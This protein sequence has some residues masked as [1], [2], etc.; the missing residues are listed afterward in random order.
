MPYFG[1][2]SRIAPLVWERF[3]RVDNLVDPFFGSGAILLAAPWPD[4]RIETVNDRDGLLTNFWRALRAFPDEVAAL[5]DYPVSELDL[6]ARHR[7]LV[8]RRAYVEHMQA[9]PEWCDVK[10][11]AW[12]V[13]GISQWIGSGWCPV[14]PAGVANVGQLSRQMPHVGDAGRGVHRAA[15]AHAGLSQQV[16][17]LSARG[18]GVAAPRLARQLPNVGSTG[19]GGPCRGSGVHRVSLANDNLSAYFQALAD[20]LRRVRIV[21]GDWTRVTG[22]SVTWR[23]GTTAAFLDPPY[24]QAGRADVYAVEGD[25]F[26]QVQAWAVEA[27][28]RKDMRIALCGYSFEMPEDWKIVRWKA[29]GG[30]G[31]QG[32]GRGR[33]NANREMIA[34]S[35]HCLDLDGLPLFAHLKAHEG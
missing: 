12:W 7:Y 30:Y 32:E 3:G 15:N 19:S 9:D 35:P 1:G 14:S 13:W 21:C 20:R 29:Q 6:H 5:A 18:R 16:P 8:D 22:P 10:L 27:G 23:H 31:S 33:E 17:D 11:A 4:D 26:R 25:I 28:A 34:F 2:K 24:A